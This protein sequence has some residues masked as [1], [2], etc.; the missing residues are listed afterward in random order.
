MFVEIRPYEDADRDA[1]LRAISVVY[2]SG[3]PPQPDDEV[4]AHRSHF[5]A[6]AGPECG[7]FYAEYHFD[8]L[9]GEAKVPTG[10]IAL[11]GVVPE[12]RHTG[13]GGDLMR[14]AL[15]DMH[16]RG[17]RLASLYPFAESWYRQFGY[18]VCGATLRFDVPKGYLPR[19]KPQLPV[20][21][22]KWS[23]FG[24]IRPCYARFSTARSGLLDRD[25]LFWGRLL[26]RKDTPSGATYEKTVYTAGTPVEAYVVMAHVPDFHAEMSV[27][28]LVWT[29][30]AGYETMLS[31][32]RSMS[33]NKSSVR[34]NEPSDSPFYY[35]H[36]S[37]SALG[38]ASLDRLIM[39]RVIDVPGAVAALQ[40]S[41]DA[42][43]TVAVDDP[44]LPENAGPWRILARGGHVVVEPTGSAEIEID[45][46][47]F[48]QAFLGQPSI[49]VVARNGFLRGSAR[50]V[51]AF[52]AVMPAA[53]VCCL[54][55]F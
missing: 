3:S 32:I 36:I 11:V 16:R 31:L 34:W 35:R 20:R 30:T 52:R 47:A 15:R 7:G 43:F 23:E 50:A 10:G 40:P 2:G 17:K 13:L 4:S 55:G 22:L 38:H 53:T 29:S 25:D 18:E 12:R 5:V 51:D 27:T 24:E 33:A 46:R 6:M 48:T 8:T 9:R 44:E 39:Y 41:A 19:L 45:I 1:L 42:E 54:D 14:F 28:E 21:R 49:D 37:S 26:G